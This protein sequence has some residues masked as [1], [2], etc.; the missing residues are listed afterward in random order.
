MDAVPVMIE[1]KQLRMRK[2]AHCLDGFRKNPTD[3]KQSKQWTAR[4]EPTDFK[5]QK[6]FWDIVQEIRLIDYLEKGKTH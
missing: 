4:E 1:N 6:N 2:S 3:N 5:L